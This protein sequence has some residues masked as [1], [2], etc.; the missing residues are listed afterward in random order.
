MK[1]LFLSLFAFIFAHGSFAQDSFV[2]M[3]EIGTGIA[4]IDLLG[5]N[6]YKATFHVYAGLTLG[7]TKGNDNGTNWYV[8]CP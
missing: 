7:I 4:V 6:Y 3:P 8:H 5:N 1:K 2:I